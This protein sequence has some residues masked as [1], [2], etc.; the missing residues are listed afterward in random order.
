MFPSPPRM[1]LLGIFLP[2]TLQRRTS[3]LTLGSSAFART[4]SPTMNSPAI[5]LTGSWVLS[6]A[7]STQ[8]IAPPS[9]ARTV[10]PSPFPSGSMTSAL[11]ARSSAV[12]GEWRMFSCSVV[13]VGF[14]TLCLIYASAVQV[15]SH[16]ICNFCSP[17]STAPLYFPDAIAR[18]SSRCPSNTLMR[19]EEPSSTCSRR[20]GV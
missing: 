1:A 14:V 7:S 9:A 20:E 17:S 11:P 8:L 15:R 10:R 16:L 3:P 18:N 12:R 6:P 2:A 4:G 5:R 19:T 13:F